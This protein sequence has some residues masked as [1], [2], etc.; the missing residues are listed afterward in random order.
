[1]DGII[2]IVTFA[3]VVMLVAERIAIIVTKWTKTKKDDEYLVEYQKAKAF[4][5]TH[6][7]GVF[8]IAKLLFDTGVLKGDGATKMEEYKKQLNDAYI[9]IEGKSL[10]DN[11]LAEA[12]LAAEGIYASKKLQAPQVT[13][14]APAVEVS[15]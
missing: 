13:A 4:V 15:E 3:F 2:D 7:N 14:S 10:P 5:L 9:K 8:D 1:M 11:V 6:A 12:E